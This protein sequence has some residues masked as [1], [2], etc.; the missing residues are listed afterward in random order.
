MSAAAPLALFAPQ[1][2]RGCGWTCPQ[3]L[4]YKHIHLPPVFSLGLYV[5]SLLLGNGLGRGLFPAPVSLT[6]CRVWIWAWTP[7]P[8]S[9]CYPCEIPLGILT[10]Q[11]LQRWELVLKGSFEDRQRAHLVVCAHPWV[12]STGWLAAQH[13]ES[14]LGQWQKHQ[15][16]RWSSLSQEF[17]NY[18]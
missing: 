15:L 14:S 6:S 11:P 8:W 12:H 9:G 10:T 13:R 5:L 17:I 1:W 16:V 4:G 2:L 18:L 3:D 7:P